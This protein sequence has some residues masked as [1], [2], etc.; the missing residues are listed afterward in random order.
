[1]VK[2]LKS[3]PKG[4]VGYV[5][6]QDGTVLEYNP[7]HPEK[8]LASGAE[9]SIFPVKEKT[10]DGHGLCLKI[11]HPEYLGN[12]DRIQKK[13][14]AMTDMDHMVRVFSLHNNFLLKNTSH[15]LGAVYSKSN[16]FIG[17]VMKHFEKVDALSIIQNKVT[18]SKFGNIN[19]RMLAEAAYNLTN[20]VGA[21]HEAGYI[22][23]DMNPKNFV[24]ERDLVVRAVDVDSFQLKHQGVLYR[25]SGRVL[26]WLHPDLHKEDW[27]TLELTQEHDYFALAKLIFQLLMFGENPYAAVYNDIEREVSAADAVRQRHYPFNDERAKSLGITTRPGVIHPRFLSKGLTRLFDRAFLGSLDDIPSPDEWHTALDKFLDVL[28]ECEINDSHSHNKHAPCPMCAMEAASKGAHTYYRESYPDGNYPALS[29]PTNTKPES[30]TETIVTYSEL[31]D[32]PH[33]IITGVMI[34]GRTNKNFVWKQGDKV[35]INNK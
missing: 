8:A 16:K 26:D 33:P 6:Q 3:L 35:Y 19:Y 24:V 7:S 17:Y 30:S 1:M 25:S 29:S 20:N 32:R 11:Y 31:S 23:G 22:I 18:F 34:C 2:P 13:I 12:N 27:T 9:G 10:K 4:F 15:P 5:T 14:E 28:V 21:I